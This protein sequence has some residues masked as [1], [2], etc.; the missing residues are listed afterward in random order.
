VAA[1]DRNRIHG[2]AA[3]LIR[4]LTEIRGIELA[5]LGRGRDTV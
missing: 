1:G 4:Q 2:L 3:Q 5:K